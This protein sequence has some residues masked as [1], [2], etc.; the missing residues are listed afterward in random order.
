MLSQHRIS[1]I[2]ARETF[3]DG[4]MIS[5]RSKSTHPF[6]LTFEIFNNNVHNCIV[7]SRTSSNVIPY[8]VCQKLNIEPKKSNIQIVQLAQSRVKVL[9]E[10]RDVFIRFFVDPQVQQTIYILMADIP[11][12]YGLLLSRDWCSQLNDYFATD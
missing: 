4:S 3:V 9:G 11:E 5:K 6:L 8:S 10:L 7:D 12:A 1:N 2:D